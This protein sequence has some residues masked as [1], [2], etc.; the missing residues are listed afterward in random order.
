M[1]KIKKHYLKKIKKKKKKE[2]KYK[3]EKIVCFSR[4]RNIQETYRNIQEHTGQ[5]I[6]ICF[7]VSENMLKTIFLSHKLQNMV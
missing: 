6:L 7:V 2:E 5:I 1:K 4:D 3:S